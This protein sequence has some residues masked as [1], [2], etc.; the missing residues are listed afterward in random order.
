MW[1]PISSLSLAPWR[2]NHVWTSRTDW[3]HVPRT[4]F[5]QKK[6]VLTC[7][8]SDV[9]CRFKFQV[10]RKR[11]YDPGLESCTQT[12]SHFPILMFMKSLHHYANIRNRIISLAIFGLTTVSCLATSQAVYQSTTICSSNRMFPCCETSA[13]HSACKAGRSQII[14]WQNEGKRHHCKNDRQSG[15]TVASKKKKT[16]ELRMGKISTKLSCDPAIL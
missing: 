11:Q 15:S 16:E 4:R 2:I 13:K 6:R 1:Y 3:L 9:L 10:V 12:H 7:K 8:I 5:R 14:A